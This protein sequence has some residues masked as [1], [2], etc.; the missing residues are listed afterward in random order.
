MIALLLVNFVLMAFERKR[1]YIRASGDTSLD[2]DRGRFCPVAGHDHHVSCLKLLYF[3]LKSS[4][5]S[6]R[7]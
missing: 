4:L 6:E 5:G 1:Y 7:K 3:D 2:A